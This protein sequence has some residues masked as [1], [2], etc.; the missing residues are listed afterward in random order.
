MAINAV[1]A[2][3]NAKIFLPNGTYDLGEATLTG[4]SGTNVS[5]IGQSM[6]NVIIKNTPATEN[7]GLGKA[8]LFINTSKDLYMQDLTLQNALDYYKAGSA[9][10]AAVLQDGGTRT[11]GKNVRMLSYQDTYYSSNNSQ[12]AYWENSDIHGTVDFICGG[13]DVRF[14]NTTISLEPRAKDGSGSRTIT[15]PTTNT[16]F[17]YVFDGCTIVD[18]ANGRVAGTTDVHGRTLQSVFTSTLRWT[19]MPRTPS[20]PSVGLKRV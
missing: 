14:Q 13:G 15:A 1:A 19:T 11:I 9:G 4:I 5:I 3:P 7:E 18:L 2:D 8:E 12:Q 6:E 16:N 20:S 17:G 10:R